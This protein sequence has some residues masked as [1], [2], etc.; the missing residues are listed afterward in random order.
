MLNENLRY[1]RKQCGYTQQQ[2]ADYLEVNRSSYTYYEVG[3]NSLPIE[4]LPS[5]C[6]LFGVSAD[7]LLHDDPVLSSVD[8]QLT[9]WEGNGLPGLA[10]LSSEERSLLL[11]LRK[12]DLTENVTEYVHK[13][14]KEKEQG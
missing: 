8:T 6:K 14:V 10:K 1:A 7:W 5:L 12:Y 2:V 3:E 13:V 9:N 4:M 11:L